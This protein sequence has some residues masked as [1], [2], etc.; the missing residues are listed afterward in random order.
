MICWNR[1]PVDMPFADS[2]SIRIDA[3]PS[4]ARPERI[5]VEMGAL[6]MAA[7]LRARATFADV[8][9]DMLDAAAV[10]RYLRSKL[11]E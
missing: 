9:L 2:I 10:C 8:S 6:A 4:S 5:V 11:G 3:N 7:K 1:G